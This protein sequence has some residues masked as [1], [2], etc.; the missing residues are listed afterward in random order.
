MTD[1]LPEDRGDR[2]ASVGGSPTMRI[3]T[4]KRR[5]A[6]ALYLLRVPFLWRAWQ[7]RWRGS[8]L[9]VL[10]THRVVDDTG[11]LSPEDRTDLA[12]GCLTRRTFKR[13]LEYLSAHWHWVSLPRLAAAAEGQA[14]RLP[15]YPAVL[16]FDDGYRDILTSAL[17]DLCV[18]RI[19]FTVFLTTGWVGST[20]RYL[21]P[22]DLARIAEEAGPLVT[23]GAHGMTHRR[24]TDLPPAEAEAEIIQS[25]Q[26]IEQWLRQ[27]ALWF[28]Y[29]DG[30]FSPELRRKLQALGFEGACATGRKLNWPPWDQFAL[31]RIPFEREPLPRFVW[32]T[33]GL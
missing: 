21:Q 10:S 17:P 28:A 7:S 1:C 23:W 5:L 15:P 13:A 11:D 25:R 3:S 19:P 32:R 9:L 8:P 20:P 22:E 2:L 6:T 14:S 16:T 4:F 12:R 18:Q 29:P 24:L 31:Q 33:V 26:I 27:P 30:A